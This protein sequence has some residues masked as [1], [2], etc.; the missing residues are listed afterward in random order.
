MARLGRLVKTTTFRLALLYTAL[1]AGSVGALFVFVFINTSVFAERQTEAAIEAEV[2]G[3]QE[4]FRREGIAGLINA[5]NRRVDPN[6][7]TDGIYILMSPGQKRL[8]GNLTSWPGDIRPD[9][10]WISFSIVEMQTA[11]A[12]TADVRGLQFI[13]SGGYRLLVGRDIR[14]ARDF[15]AQLLRSL[16]IGLGITV[17]LG[18]VGGFL[19]SRTIMGRVER[20]TQT[21]RRIM[22]GDLSQRIDTAGQSDELSRL[23]ESVNEMLD[24]IERLMNGLRE[25]S[26]NVA[27]DLRTPLNR[28]RVRLEVAVN[29][30][31]DEK[32]KEELEEAI[33][34]A[35]RLLATF[36]SLLRIA[37][38]EASLRRSFETVDLGS[39]VEDVVDLYQPLAEEKGIR[40]ESNVEF[41]VKAW[42][43][44]N[45]IAQALANLVDN[46]VKYTPNGGEVMVSLKSESGLA[47]L[48]VVDSGPGIPEAYREKVFGRLY[49]L[50]DS[51]STPGSGLG[52]SLVWA[53][54]KSHG[55]SIDLFD[56]TPGL[57][58]TVR[59]PE[60]SIASDA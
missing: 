43:D 23:S 34:D 29:N 39:I 21:C 10:L 8:A 35:D 2:T 42:G 52:L 18:V 6:F 22:R 24:Q 49:R 17:A 11:D 47:S 38:A 53:V 46:A 55:L 7:R 36:S 27:H 9:D 31:V 51:R 14:E 54:G 32:E 60:A 5:I 45:L 30:A 28:L 15:R 48:T 3:L 57:V 16:N 25:V 26:D 56:N 37:R 59:F 1:F 4:T 19:F 58:V 13:V 40:F 44:P 41:G 33:A 12:A 50:D 20:I